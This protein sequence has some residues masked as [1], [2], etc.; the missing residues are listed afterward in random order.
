MYLPYHTEA[1]KRK[2]RK[3]RKKD[4]LRF[5][6]VAKKIEEIM[7]NPHVY[8]PLGNELAGRRRVH[9][10]PFV[11]VFRIDEENKMVR[12]LDYDHHDKIYKN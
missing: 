6:R 5:D 2:M 3:L 8:K 1:F 4:R 11:L 9:F 10:D 7:E 12:F